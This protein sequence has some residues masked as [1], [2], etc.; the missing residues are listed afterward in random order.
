VPCR[1]S[2]DSHELADNLLDVPHIRASRKNENRHRPTYTDP[3]AAARKLLESCPIPIRIVFMNRLLVTALAV[4]LP[5]LANAAD[6]FQILPLG[7]QM[8]TNNDF[9]HRALITNR[10]ETGGWICSAHT[11][12]VDLTV[13]AVFC[14]KA[15]IAGTM[16]AGPG[17]LSQIPPSATLPGLW[18][19]DQTDG[20]VTFCG[21]ADDGAAW[22][23]KQAEHQ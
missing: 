12:P 23:C 17:I 4:S 21:A 20:K 10:T 3:E 11:H 2:F 22:V 6:Q 16:P 15:K 14:T 1:Q 7:V 8:H 19:V 13:D 18:K 9:E 5:T